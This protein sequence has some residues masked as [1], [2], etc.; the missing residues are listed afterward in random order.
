MIKDLLQ[1]KNSLESANIKVDKI[2]KL[3]FIGNHII[4]DY[5]IEIISVDKIDKGLEILA[6]AWQGEKQLGFGSD[7]SVD[8]ERFRIFNP[9]ILIQDNNGDIVKEVV[10]TL[11]KEIRQVK[12]RESLSEAVLETLIHTIKISAKE[13]Q[14][15]SG[16]IGN[17]TSTFY[18]DAN[19]ETSSVD[20]FIGN[21]GGSMSWATVRDE[22][23]ASNFSFPLINS[24]GTTID[25]FNRRSSD[26]VIYRAFT[27]FDT[28]LLHDTTTIDSAT[29]SLFSTGAPTNAGALT[30]VLVQSSPA[31]STDLV[32]DDYDQC[33]TKNTPT[34]GATRYALSNITDSSYQNISLN[35]TGLGWISK[36]GVTKFGL[37]LS[38]DVDDSNPDSNNHIV[39]FYSA[40]QAG[41]TNDPKLVVVHSGVSFIPKITII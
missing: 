38:M 41:T 32:G 5:E 4:N 23:N 2:V 24:S 34:E 20:G 21:D 19:V 30:I 3:D 14:I 12:Y 17:T 18:P 28:S 25:L 31:S 1:G 36:T 26:S 29:L 22:T 16:K 27:L 40:D 9:P 11:T 15:I 7:G 6:R 33:G 13:G 10:D 37:R 35:A 39:N 8:I